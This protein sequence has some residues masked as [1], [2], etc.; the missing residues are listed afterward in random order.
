[1]PAP[2]VQA[3]FALTL[4][5]LSLMV[6]RAVNNVNSGRWPG[7]KAWSLYLRVLLGFMLAAAVTLAFYAFAGIDILSR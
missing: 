6:A 3:L 4:F 5:L 2:N 7:G 1:M